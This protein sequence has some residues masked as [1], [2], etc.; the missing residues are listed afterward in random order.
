MNT[1]VVVLIAMV[2]LFHGSVARI[3]DVST[4]A[5]EP[6]SATPPTGL[7]PE[8]APTPAP[9]NGAVTYTVG[10]NIGWTV[11]NDGASAYV[12]WA[13]SKNFKVG[14]IL[15]FNYQ[16]NAHNVE[17]VTK[18]KYDSCNHVSSLSIYRNTPKRVTLNKSG[19]H[20]F[21]CGVP[22][23]CSVGQKLAINVTATTTTAT[24]T[25]PSS[26]ATPPSTSTTLSFSPPQNSGPASLG[27]FGTVLYIVVSFFY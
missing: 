17:E 16:K 8:S 6:I 21:I 4:P 7:I 20:Y 25:A 13:S 3:V 9:S 14:D 27:L 2:T 10:D 11:P 5:P 19:P 22:G 24:A 18:E 26:N 23:H 1:F 12:T 15:V